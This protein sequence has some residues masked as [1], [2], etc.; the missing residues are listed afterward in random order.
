M[1]RC[2]KLA[3]A[4]GCAVSTL[5]GPEAREGRP[6]LDA[7]LEATQITRPPMGYIQFCRDFPEDCHS[8]TRTPRVVTLTKPRWQELERINRTVNR[9]IQPVTDQE[10]YHVQE[11]WTYPVAKGDCEDYVLLKRKILVQH[12]WPE[13][14]LLITVVRDQKGDGHAV[15]TARTNR[16]DYILDNQADSIMA[17]RDT[18]YRFV[19]RQAEWDPTVWVNLAAPAS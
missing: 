5:A 14:A 16:G 13:E 4:A 17:W 9:G 10:L 8:G 12:G 11:R 19:K 7:I 1:D 18:G 15:L 6:P 3:L 2:I